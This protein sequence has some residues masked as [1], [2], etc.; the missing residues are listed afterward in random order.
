MA[1]L[2][3]DRQPLPTL[4]ATPLQDQST[5]FRGHANEKP[6]RLPAPACIRLKCALTLH[7]LSTASATVPGSAHL[8]EV[9]PFDAQ[10][11]L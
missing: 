10:P 4:G 2:A 9:K 11:Q 8:E 3:A 5:V 7:D 6:V 1:L